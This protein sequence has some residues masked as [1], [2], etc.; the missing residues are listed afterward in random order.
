MGLCVGEHDE[1]LPR[2]LDVPAKYAPTLNVRMGMHS[3][4]EASKYG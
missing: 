1:V 4:V 3:T 2:G